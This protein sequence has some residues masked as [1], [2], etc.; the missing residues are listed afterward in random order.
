MGYSK[1]ELITMLVVAERKN[2]TRTVTMP[3]DVVPILVRYATRK[4]E[5]FVAIT[6]TSAHNVIRV[7]VVTIGILNLTIVHPREVFAHAI[8]DR[9]DAIIIAHNHPSGALFPSTDDH[10][11]TTRMIQAGTLLG[12][13]VLDHVI[14]SKNGYYSFRENGNIG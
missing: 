14:I 12:I 7:H 11:V 13:S 6:L 9:A 5:H 1:K 4:Q 3:S 10:G 8:R 2:P